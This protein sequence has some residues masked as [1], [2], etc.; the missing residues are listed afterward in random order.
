MS[1]SILLSFVYTYHHLI[2]DF[3]YILLFHLLFLKNATNNSRRYNNH[4]KES[5]K[6]TERFIKGQYTIERANEKIGR[7]KIERLILQL[8]TGI[9]RYRTRTEKQDFQNKMET[10]LITFLVGLLLSAIWF[11][12]TN[13]S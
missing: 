13:K 2:H 8:E 9:E 4:E 12:L 3:L 5:T 10:G 7:G 1:L 6:C 11:Q